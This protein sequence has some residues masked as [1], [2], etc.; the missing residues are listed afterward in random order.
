NRID[1]R[2]MFLPLTKDEIKMIARLMLKK[3]SKNINAQ[4]LKIDLSEGALDLITEMGYDPQFGARPLKRVI[5]KEL[6][7]VLAREIL[8]GDY[9]AGDTI[10]IAV[11]K[12]NFVFSKES[13]NDDIAPVIQE[14]NV[15]KKT[16]RRGGGSGNHTEELIKATKDLEDTIEAIK[17]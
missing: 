5:D 15:Q 14:S 4:G 9:A 13:L 1:E 3:L 16:R 8:G 12:N 2:I 10:H 6:I 11:Q 17:Q 7:N